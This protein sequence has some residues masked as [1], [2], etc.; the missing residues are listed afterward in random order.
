MAG[1]GVRLNRIFSQKSIVADMVGFAYSMMV[2]VAPMFLVI[3]NILLMGWVLGFGRIGYAQRELFSCTV[4]YIFIFALL[5]ASPFNAVLSKYMS[6]IIYEER[7]QD[8]LPCYY[9]GMLFNI[10]LSCLFGIP[11]CLWEHFVGQVPVFYVFLGF[12]G[13]ISLALVFYSMLYLSI[14]K[15]YGKISLFFFLGMLVAFLLSLLMCFVFHWSITVSM[16]FSLTVGFFV[17]A[18]LELAV[19][20]R[21]FQKNSNQYKPVLRYFKKYWKLV[22]TNLLYTLGLYIHNFVFWCTDMRLVVVDSFICCQPYDMASCLAM[23][24]NISA[25]I[26]FIAH[27]EMHFHDKYKAYSEAVI[28]GKWADIVNTKRQM[29]RQL[30]AEL[31]NLVRVQFIISVSVYLLCMVLLPRI[32]FSGM[33]MHIYPCLAA[34]YFILFLMYSTI[35]FLYYFDDLT[36]AVLSSLGFCLVTLLG[37]ILS[38]H[39]PERWYGLGVVLGSFFGWTIAYLRLRRIEKN[40]DAHI[41]CRDTLIQRGSGLRPSS[42]VYDRSEARAD[43]AAER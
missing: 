36:G 10:V 7:Y 30:G 35:L 31:M 6:D 32:G 13:Y 23:F 9:L 27:V 3:L 39:L 4:L 28:G 14:C 21:Y 17:T 18:C 25:T 38:T 37:S 22:L 33:V 1:I 8:I 40:M 19:V 12:C 11:F 5:T 15:D 16:L 2:T 20:K 41:F 29:F 24:T 43:A 34:G 42:K 26:I